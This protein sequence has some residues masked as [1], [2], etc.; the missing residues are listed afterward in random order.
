MHA[1]VSAESAYNPKAVSSAGAIGLMQV[2][3]ATA[4]DYGV[5]DS[6]ALFDPRVNVSTGVRH[7]KRLLRKYRNDYGR[8]IMAYNAGEGVVDR[9][10]SNVTYAETLSYTEAVVRRY[11]K[12]GGTQPTDAVLRKVSALRGRRG[13]AKQNLT[14]PSESDPALI[15]PK[16]SPSLEVGRLLSSVGVSSPRGSPA[17]ATATGQRVAQRSAVRGALRTGIDPAIR[18]AATGRLPGGAPNSRKGTVHQ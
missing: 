14:P 13:Q 1:V 5:S 16:V 6:S 11:R 17:S 7:L 15:L 10:D 8:V 2:M 12:L 3:P 18:G 9:T 4:G